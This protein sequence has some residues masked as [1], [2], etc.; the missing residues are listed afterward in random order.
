MGAAQAHRE[1]DGSAGAIVPAPRPHRQRHDGFTPKKQRKFLKAL[2]KTGCLKDAARAAGISCNTVRRHRDKWQNFDEKVDVA[3]AIASGELETIAWKRAVEGVEEK[4]IRDGKVAWI[5][6]KPSDAILRLLMKGAD[7]KKY[8]AAGFSRKRLRAWERK[9]IEEEV[10]A[11]IRAKRPTFEESMQMLDTR[12]RALGLRHGIPA[13]W[14][15]PEP[16]E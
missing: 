6:I 9:Q 1:A 2:K 14:E 7:P 5:R 11:E 13:D 8:G 3:L 10:R 4:V 12:L 16:G 15:P